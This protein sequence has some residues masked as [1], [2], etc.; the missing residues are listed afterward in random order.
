MYQ[1]HSS[2]NLCQIHL[3]GHLP[4]FSLFVQEKKE[5][6]RK[7]LE[8]VRRRRKEIEKSFKKGAATLINTDPLSFYILLIC[9]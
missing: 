6:R 5:K 9:L 7:V 3:G 2:P 1:A 4:P 8:A